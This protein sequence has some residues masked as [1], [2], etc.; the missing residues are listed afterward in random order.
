[1]VLLQLVWPVPEMLT[2]DRSFVPF[3]DPID[4]YF[5]GGQWS[6]GDRALLRAAVRI[7]VTRAQR[8]YVGSWWPED[9]APWVEFLAILI[10]VT[11]DAVA[12]KWLMPY[13]LMAR[14]SLVTSFNQ[15]NP[16]LF[17]EDRTVVLT[18]H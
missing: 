7:R 11:A 15:A 1:M 5:R 17:V 6:D 12:M 3:G 18:S 9:S 10:S 2:A 16:G 13:D 14:L 4:G 8:E